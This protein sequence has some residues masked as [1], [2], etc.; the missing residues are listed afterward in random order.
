MLYKNNTFEIHHP[1]TLTDLRATTLSRRLNFIRRVNIRWNTL[2]PYQSFDFHTKHPSMFG[3][4]VWQ[5][6]WGVVAGMQGLKVLN[7]FIIGL[8][9]ARAKQVE[10]LLKPMQAVKQC[11]EFSVGLGPTLE[12][13]PHIVSP[14][15]LRILTPE[16]LADLNAE[17]I[18]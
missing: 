15:K 5:E 13:P 1:W 18:S 17:R 6:F 12:A 7:V 2:Y 16:E 9:L 3:A 14:F 11:D 10:E 4:I 8:T